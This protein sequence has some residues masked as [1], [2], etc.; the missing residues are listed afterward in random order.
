MKARLIRL[1]F[2]IAGIF[3]FITAVAKIISGSG[4]SKVLQMPDPILMISFQQ[5]FWLVGSLELLIACVCL[6]S[7]RL[8]LQAGLIAWLATSF[9]MY[10]IGL[11]LSGYHKPCSC[12]GNLTDAI[13]VSPQMADNI[14]KGGLAYLLIGSYAT[15]FRL[16]RQH[17]K[18]APAP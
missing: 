3:L 15:L 8:S 5:I 14:M 13:H 12:M 17:K 18:P 4:A 1:F 9:A 6:F 11:L 7:K 2:F 16:W 10:R